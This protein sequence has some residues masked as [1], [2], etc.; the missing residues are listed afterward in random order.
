MSSSIPTKQLD[1]DVSIGRNVAIGG[2]ATVQ[3]SVTVGHNLKVEGWLDAKNIKGPNKGLFKTVEQLRETY[4]NPHDGWWALVGDTLPAP[5]YRGDGGEWVATGESGGNPTIDSTEYMEAVEELTKD[6]T[7]VKVDVAQNESDIKSLRSTQTTQGD[8]INT[9]TNRVTSVE[10]DVSTLKSGL[11]AEQTARKEAIEALTTEVD[12]LHPVIAIDDIDSF[13]ASL[14]DAAKMAVDT[15]HSRYVVKSGRLSVGVLDIFSDNMGHSLTEIFTSHYA[16]TETDN[17]GYTLN[18]NEHNDSQLT[19]MFRSYAVSSTGGGAS[20]KGQW[21]AWKPLAKQYYDGLSGLIT[22]EETARKEADEQ[23]K[24]QLT[25]LITDEE[26]NRT[27]G[28]NQLQAQL[29]NRCVVNV[30]TLLDAPSREFTFSVVLT[31]VSEL[32][33][34]SQYMKPGV[35]LTFLSDSGWQSKQWTSAT[36]STEA[37][38]QET[39]WTDFGANGTAVGN[40]V[41]VNDVCDDIEY[42]L[43]T[44][45]K[46]IQDKETE[47]GMSYFKS[48]IVLTYRTAEV[49]S[50]GSPV[51][52]AYQFTRD[53]S[54]INPADEKPWAEFGGGGSN[55]STSDEPEADGK[56]AF[57]TGGAYSHIP[58]NIKLDTETGGVVKMQLVNEA[59]DGIGDEVQFAVGT[60]SGESTGTIVSIQLKESP[61]YA[62]AGG[63]V[64]LQAAVRSITT[65]GGQELS[66]MIETVLLKDRDTGQTLE[67][68]KFN[69]ASSASSDTYDFA[70]DVS[71]YFTS[72]TTKRFQLIATDDAGNT[73][74]RNV[75]VSGVDVTISSVQTL[76]YTSATALTVG[77]NMK[78]IPMYK[79]ANNAS[80]KGIK[81]TT[82]IAIDGEWKE[83]GTS[84]VLDTYSH[85]ISIDP[86]SCC[87]TT[88]KHGAYALRIHGEDIGS[89]VVGNYLHTAVMVIEDGNNTPI[90]ATRWLTDSA[91]GTKKLYEEISIDYAVYVA[92]NDEPKAAI[93]YDGEEV[94]SNIAYRNETNTYTK[95][96]LESV[97]D[98]TK[99]VDVY[100]TCGS[101]SSQTASFVIDGS[102]VD[103][104]EVSTQREFNILMDSRSNSE[105]DKTIEDEGTTISVENCNWSS[106]GFVK[107]T[108]GTASYASGSG[109]MA[110]RIAEDMKAVC[111]YKPFA[112]GNIEQN[113]MAVSFT[114]K[115]KNVED[116]TAKLIDCLGDAS[117]GFYLTGEKL[118]FVCDGNEAIA[119]YATD[120]ET[121]FDIVVEPSSIAPYSGIG[122]IKLFVNGDFAAA[123]YYSSGKLTTQEHTINFDGTS[124]DIYL[125][126]LTAWATY[127]NYRQAF[128]NYVVGLKD[129]TAM[130]SEYEKN[131]VMASM[132]AEGTT[133]DRPTLQACQDAGLC[134]VTLLKNADTADVASSYPGYLD[135]LDGDKK[136]AC[137]FDWVMRWPDRPWQDC[138]IYKVKTTNQGTTSSM[139][140]IK[141]KKGKFKGCVIELLH[142]EDD[143]K[144]DEAALAKFKKC[145]KMAAKSKIQIIDDGL[146]IKTCTIKVDY[147]D[148]TGANNGA[149]MELMNKLQRAMG[150]NYMTPSQVYYDGD[151]T[152]NTSIDSVP[153]GLFRTDSQSAD[154][155]NET[156]AYFHAKAN[157]NVDKGNPDFF[158]FENASGYNDGCLN[159]GDF[160][161][162]VTDKTQTLAAL[163]TAT[164]AD[165]SGLIASNIYVLTEYC[166]KSYVVLEN[167]GTGKMTETDAV[168]SPTELNETLADV[169]AEDVTD[170]DWGTVYLTSD[171]KYVKYTGGNWKDTTGK[172]SYDK[173]TNKWSISGRVV[174]PVECFEYLKYDSLCWLQGVNSVDDLMALTDAGTPVWMDYYESRYPDDDDLNALYEAGKKVP[175]NLYQWLLWTQQCSHMLTEDDGIITLHGA[176]VAGT[177]ENRLKKWS[178]E[179]FEHANVYSTGCYIV[180]SDY[181]LAVDQRSKNMMIGFYLDTDGRVKAYFNHWHDGDGVWLADNDCGITVPWDLDSVDDPQHYYQGWNSVMFK[182]GYAADKYWLS[183]NGA[184][185]ITLHDIASAMRNAEADGIKIFSAEGCQKLW[186]TDRL[187]KFAKVTSSF[188]GE[189]KYIENSKTG[190]NYFYAVHGLRLEDLPVTFEKRFAYRDGYYQVGALYNNPFKFRAVGT[191]IAIKITAAQDG[192]FGIGVDRADT[193]VDSCYLKAGESYTLKT[194]MTATGSGTM[195]YIFGAKQVGVLD[196]S[197]CTP[198][199]ALD[200]SNC[201]LLQELIWGGEDYVPTE[202]SSAITEIEVGTAPFLRKVDVRNATNITSLKVGNC[203]RL[204]EVLAGGSSLATIEI[205][206]NAPLATLALPATMT[207]LY[208]KNLTKLQYPGGLTF[209]GM[210]SLRSI[211]ISGCG[212]VDCAQLLLDAVNGGSKIKTIGLVG[213][214]VYGKSSVLQSLIDNGA[215]GLDANG[216]SYGESG[217]CSGLTGTWIMEDYIADSLLE[218]LQAYFPKLTVHNSQF[219]IVKIS[220]VVANDSCEKYSN[221]ENE[222]GADYGNTYVASGH[223]KAIREG[224]HAYKCS[225]NSKLGQME[226]VQLSDENFNYLANGKSIDLSDVVGE[227]FDIMWHAPH[228]W[229][230]GVNDYKKQEKYYLSSKLDTEPM[231]TATKRTE[232]LLSTLLYREGSGVYTDA[233]SV[234]EVMGDDAIVTTA[235][236]NTYKMDVE[237]MKQVRWPGLNHA[238]LGGVFTD[239]D[240]VVVG[241]FNM[242]VSHIY[243]DF[244]NGEYVFCDVPDGAKWYYFTSYK[245]IDDVKCLAVDSSNIEAIEP[246]WVEHTVGDLDSLVGIYPITID[247]LKMPRS[248]SGNVRSRKGDGTS[249]TSGEWTY[250]TDG[251][252]RTEIPVNTI[253]YTC[254]DFQNLSRMRGAGYQLQDYEQHKE[255]A[256]LWWALHGTT[257]EQA[258]VGNGAHDA[259]LNGQDSIGM[260]DTAYVGNALNSLMGL[261]H[262]V[263]CDSE[264]L[265]YIGFNIPDYATWYKAK[266]IDSDNSYPID[267]VAHIYD[268]VTKTERTVQSVQDGSGHCVVRVVH[269]AKCDILASK[270]HSSD[271]SKYVTHYAAGH[272]LSGSRG[273]VV[274]RSGNSSF[275]NGGLACAC[276]NYAS[277]LSNAYNG[278]RLAFRG[279]FVI[280][281]ESE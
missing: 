117:M 251:E 235:N 36:V 4:P 43:S 137:Y 139:R 112:S 57:S 271:T 168:A 216:K 134:C 74:S 14:E 279:K 33:E 127:F 146:W 86:K 277:S 121:R 180:G 61:V 67:T 52:K 89:G 72:A 53:V 150:N 197:G 232:A 7:A 1:G 66:N 25:D 156:Y 203:P 181:I 175:Y 154:A 187:N 248:I 198:I 233:V 262:Y 201:D 224:V 120:K 84:T 193:C 22:D 108:Y 184:D 37:W 228:Y 105:D 192:F 153:A 261:K 260:S 275:A 229:Y 256:N 268:P 145:Q 148:S 263:G 249:Q 109:R 171:G 58:T 55:V 164:L 239:A 75:N 11:E 138:K 188:D 123:C 157:V 162:I 143:F 267:Y 34:A 149:T 12:G 176:T 258:V 38:L 65:Q 50:N 270:V 170:F 242:S 155:T 212:K 27:E 39:N 26:T 194:G 182:Q 24:T 132:T 6:I 152:M 165:T 87:G 185:T 238:R 83:L 131:Q 167:D 122:C 60:G 56:E 93:Y 19:Q 189:R 128:N 45:I 8:T 266:C 219:S 186:I 51:W 99:S 97:H 269:G 10:S 107:D 210:T 206:D 209:E 9:L 30:N 241:T 225:Y 215:T 204:A 77:G 90:V 46:A 140:P 159:Y 129:T 21:S 115:V 177:K 130:L 240:G 161:E 59:N 96:V 281:E 144:D 62:K 63:S 214:H 179:L 172:M 15:K 213:L 80:D 95:Q 125:Y 49:S 141:N 243:F 136:T 35:V 106:N 274:L 135:T 211:Y 73:G 76:N 13:P 280:V 231:S 78:N 133:K 178:E 118:V 2:K 255:I 205:A 250:D 23:L 278:A 17:G 190:A 218:T 85:S 147:S 230:K 5:I 31:K 28:D 237:G 252:P 195:L 226:G 220:D 151:G 223:V 82:E 245:D 44:A 71:S 54:D 104:E 254:K 253:H 234:G 94:S 124:A 208:F 207:T 40:T 169:Q 246:E 257:N 69:K 244:V 32:D 103:V 116:R 91:R 114:L 92:N 142:T 217:Q 68:F 221:P 111:S 110:L 196:V 247:G 48:G 16:Y 64:I 119:L 100:V 227:G 42:T 160:V 236:V 191:D 3:G 183:A 29:L 166:G 276:A 173:S 102:L 174:N 20:E 98:G 265:D 199:S 222:T 70:M 79:F 101:S 200:L 202:G 113:G 47:S 81:V 273:R 41:N 264:W 259:I 88:L 163:K 272:W 18:T 126:K 158:G